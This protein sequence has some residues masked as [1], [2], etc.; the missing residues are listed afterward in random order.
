MPR[1]ASRIEL[2]AI[3]HPLD[4][5]RWLESPLGHRSAEMTPL[6]IERYH[7]PRED[8]RQVSYPYWEFT[9][10]IQGT[11]TM[12]SL[13]QRLEM[14]PGTL[15]LIP[16]GVW[17]YEESRTPVDTIWLAF[18]AKHMPDRLKARACAIHSPTIAA[19]GEQVG[20]PDPMYFS[21]IF[22]GVW[23][24]PGGSGREP[25]ARSVS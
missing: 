9:A 18:Q 15:C 10:S 17:A 5:K 12:H 22:R 16:P 20:Y 21:R 23:P 8:T 2:P 6:Y 4:D 24:P 14:S 1:R 13:G 11:Y 25:R 7:G 3:V 19:I